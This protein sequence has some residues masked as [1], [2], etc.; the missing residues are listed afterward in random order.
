MTA[1]TGSSI[2]PPL[3][4]LCHLWPVRAVER[5]AL[6]LEE[7]IQPTLATAPL[8]IQYSECPFA[9]RLL[10]SNVLPGIQGAREVVQMKLSG[11]RSDRW[12][13]WS[14]L[15]EGSHILFPFVVCQITSFRPD[16]CMGD[17][18]A[19][20]LLDGEVRSTVALLSV[21]R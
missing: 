17:I 21:L 20:Y 2:F 19:R 1:L 13:F 9:R 4:Y 6:K 12:L 15:P 3:D 14:H 16:T 7:E 11:V 8:V 5:L 18:I 10:L